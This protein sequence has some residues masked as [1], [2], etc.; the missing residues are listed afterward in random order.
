MVTTPLSDCLTSQAFDRSI[1]SGQLRVVQLIDR[2]MIDSLLPTER[3]SWE[4]RSATTTHKRELQNEVWTSKGNTWTRI[5]NFVVKSRNFFNCRRVVLCWLLCLTA[6]TAVTVIM[7]ASAAPI[8][9]AEACNFKLI[10]FFHFFKKS[11]FPNT[12]PAL[13][14]RSE[15]F[16]FLK[17][18]F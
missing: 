18:I 7:F 5:F 8:A 10:T 2:K 15:M 4:T 1:Q 17:R 11:N 13:F 14:I 3:S 16:E 12:E 9:A 6:T